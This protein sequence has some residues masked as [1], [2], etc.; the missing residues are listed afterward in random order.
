MQPTDGDGMVPNQGS[1]LERFA[2]KGTWSPFSPRTVMGIVIHYNFVDEY[3]FK[4]LADP[5]DI[6]C[7]S[8][9]P[10][11]IGVEFFSG[12]APSEAP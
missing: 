9:P 8:R 11:S 7:L 6:I 12:L 10:F 5:H 3:T 1:P 2:F 4:R